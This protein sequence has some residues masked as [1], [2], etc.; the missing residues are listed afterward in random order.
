MKISKSLCSLNSYLGQ[1]FPKSFKNIYTEINEQ[2]KEYELFLNLVGE[3][4][5]TYIEVQGERE[6]TKEEELKR[7][8]QEETS[9]KQLE[10][11]KLEEIRKIKKRAKELGLK[12]E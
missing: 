12:I 10:S 5:G 4:E 9:K 3:Y 8:K 7:I 6:E 2:Y 1:E 11:R